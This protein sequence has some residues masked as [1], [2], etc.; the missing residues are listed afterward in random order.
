MYFLLSIGTSL[1]ELVTT[2]I[3]VKKK[4]DEIGIGNILGSNLV[5]LLFVFGLSTFIRPL[6]ISNYI[7]ELVFLT[8]VSLVVY[9]FAIAGKK[10]TFSKKEGA[11]LVLLYSIFIATQVL[12]RT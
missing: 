7:P 8:G 11:L 6:Y 1:P 12:N 3:A 4:N 2:W 9:F 5:N 10:Y